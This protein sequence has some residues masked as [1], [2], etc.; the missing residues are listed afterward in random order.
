MKATYREILVIN[1]FK[2]ASFLSKTLFLSLLV[3]MGFQSTP[4]NAEP[5]LDIRGIDELIAPQ[6]KQYSPLYGITAFESGRLLGMRFYGNF[7]KEKSDIP[8]QKQITARDTDCPLDWNSALIQQLFPSPDGLALSTN[9]IAPLSKL[10]A[11]SFG[12]LLERIYRFENENA[13]SE[14]VEDELVRI[15]YEGTHGK[16]LEELAKSHKLFARSLRPLTAEKKAIS[17]ECRK[18]MGNEEKLKELYQDIQ[19][20]DDKINQAATEYLKKNGINEFKK[21]AAWQELVPFANILVNAVQ[22]A[23][24]KDSLYSPAEV[25]TAYVWRKWDRKKE[26]FLE[27]MRGFSSCLAET[28]RAWVE[29]DEFGEEKSAW[30]QPYEEGKYGYWL[31]QFEGPDRPSKTQIQEL[32][33]QPELSVHYG[34]MSKASKLL[35]PTLPGYGRAEHKSLGLNEKTTNPRRKYNLYSDCGEQSLR[36][37]F[38]IFLYN[39]EKEMLDPSILEDIAKTY[40]LNLYAPPPKNPLKERKR[41]KGLL[42]FYQ[43]NQSLKNVGSEEVRD[44]WSKVVS[45]LPGVLY[46]QGGGQ[47]DMTGGIP[48]ILAAFEALLGDPEWSKLNSPAQ[49]WDRVCQ[50]FSRDGFQIDWK[51]KGAKASNEKQIE[52]D[53]GVTLSFLINRTHAFDWRFDRGHF[54]VASMS[55]SSDLSPWRIGIGKELVSNLKSS[56]HA[57]VALPWYVDVKNFKDFTKNLKERQEISLAKKQLFNLPLQSNEMKLFAIKQVLKEFPHESDLAGPV[58]KWLSMIPPDDVSNVAFILIQAFNE[59][60][61]Y[62]D[63]MIDQYLN[64]SPIEIQKEVLVKIA[65]ESLDL[66][67]ILLSKSPQAISAKSGY[68]GKTLLHYAAKGGDLDLV[69]L[70]LVRAPE[71]IFMK[72]KFRNPLHEAVLKGYLEIAQHL[73]EKNPQLTLENNEMEGTPLHFAVHSGQLKIVQWTYKMNRPALREWDEKGRTPSHIAAKYGL[74]D[75]L[76]FFNKK[77]PDVLLDKDIKGNTLMH[78]AA[79]HGRLKIVE[80]LAEMVPE[81]LNVK[82]ANSNKPLDLAISHGHEEVVKFLVE[83]SPQLILERDKRGNTPFDYAVHREFWCLA[84]F[85]AEKNPQ[86]LSRDD[87]GRN[88]IDK[89]LLDVAIGGDLNKLK[90]LVEFGANLETAGD[91]GVTPLAIAAREGWLENVEFL[92]ENGANIEA[93][94]VRGFTPLDYAVAQGR[95]EVVKYLI[96]RGANLDRAL[97]LA[98]RP[99]RRDSQAEIVSFITDYKERKASILSP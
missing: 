55:N 74:L 9:Q 7:G 16:A 81:T 95:L 8:C 31:S 29:K 57:N 5:D 59:K 23:R 40:S 49:K 79:E 67:R 47:C 19:V 35:L 15:L 14:G 54:A 77:N 61:P 10:T 68:L 1:G 88:C 38:N 13:S 83:K 17:K 25:L 43:R 73:V 6:C 70:V 34:Y 3:V 78:Y 41:P 50:L 46:K 2:I 58:L 63:E 75:I 62:L 22:E 64:R 96:Q 24:Q 51:V 37:A 85:M 84:N 45:N 98:N 93:P 33:S 72:S 26:P 39:R 60:V 97:E 20:I 42:S 80:Y 12:K 71:L 94:N 36:D 32:I 30:L 18:N 90:Y 4:A 99:N 52:Q 21:T 65:S 87:R 66:A 44:Y 48:T 89:K 91:N 86:V 92:V 82:N 27:L 11:N 69:K 53:V 76:R 56:P 28:H